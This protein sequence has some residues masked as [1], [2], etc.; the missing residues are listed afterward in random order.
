MEQE[1]NSFYRT[2]VILATVQR[3][4]NDT[5]KFILKA[6][7]AWLSCDSRPLLGPGPDASRA[8]NIYP[9]VFWGIMVGVA[10]QKRC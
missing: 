4:L 6:I 1:S 5:V 9:N 3:P 2:E 10:K 7:L 8:N